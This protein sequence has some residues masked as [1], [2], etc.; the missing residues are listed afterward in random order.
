MGVEA[1]EIDPFMNGGS[2]TLELARAVVEVSRSESHFEFLYPSD[3]P[4]EEKLETVATE[5]YGAD[6]VDLLAGVHDKLQTYSSLGFGDLPICIAKTQYS[7]SHDP[8]LLG[9]QTGFRLPIRDVH[10]ASGV[11]LIYAIAGDTSTMPGLPRNPAAQR[12]DIDKDGRI[13]G[14]Q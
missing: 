9:R 12:I 10:L 6:G 5:I 4:L 11:G 13:V 1:I 8:K 14:L 3:L 7:L 2:G